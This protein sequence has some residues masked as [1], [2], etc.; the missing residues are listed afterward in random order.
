M[1][2][3]TALPT[4]LVPESDVLSEVSSSVAAL[5]VGQ[6]G[7]KAAEISP[8]RAKTSMDASDVEQSHELSIIRTQD[9]FLVEQAQ[10]LR[11]LTFFGGRTGSWPT[12]HPQAID[13]DEFDQYCEHLI[14][15]DHSRIENGH[16]KVVGTYRLRVSDLQE[17][18][19]KNIQLYTA[20]EFDLSQLMQKEGKVLELGRSCVHPDYRSGDVIMNLWSGIG[21][22]LATHTI[23]YMIGCVS[24]PKANVDVHWDSLAYI[25]QYHRADADICPQALEQVKAHTD[26]DF[27]EMSKVEGKA[28]FRQLPPLLKAYI[29]MGAR[30]GEG[31]V[32]DPVCDTLDLCVVVKCADID[33]RYSKRFIKA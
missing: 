12:G 7:R 27:P 31:A 23:D 18:R 21:E 3:T 2:Q 26:T 19:E 4:F 22:F 6:Q 5:G 32:L 14:V 13:R 17:N 10:R 8:L 16:P 9:P 20:T 29:R 15:Q 25:K 28:V 30:F 33:P 24:F 11:Y 1:V